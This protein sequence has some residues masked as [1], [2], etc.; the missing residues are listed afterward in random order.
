MNR[1]YASDQDP[2]EHFD[3]CSS[4]RRQYGV[5]FCF[6]RDGMCLCRRFPN[7]RRL[8]LALIAN[9]SSRDALYEALK[10]AM[11]DVEITFP[12]ADTFDY[13]REASERA[14]WTKRRPGQ[15]K[16]KRPRWL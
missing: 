15:D 2:L 6:W 16:A 5:G 3:M 1:K 13:Y 7:L 9:I 12:D 10:N 11:P 14:W 8:H 4:T